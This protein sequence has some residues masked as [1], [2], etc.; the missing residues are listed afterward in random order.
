MRPQLESLLSPLVRSPLLI[1]AGDFNSPLSPLDVSN[2]HYAPWPMLSSLVSAAPPTLLNIARCLHPDSPLFS[3]YPSPLHPNSQSLLDHL[4]MTPQCHQLLPASTFFI[5]ASHTFSDHYPIHAQLTAPPFTHPTPMRTFRRPLSTQEAATF[6]SLFSTWLPQVQ[7][8]ASLPLQHHETLTAQ[9]L[10]AAAQAYLQVTKRKYRQRN[11]ANTRDALRALQAALEVAAEKRKWMAG[12]A[13]HKAFLQRRQLKRAMRSYTPTTQPPMP[14]LRATEQS[15]ATASPA[16]MAEL[17]CHTLARLGGQQD[18]QPPQSLLTSLLQHH[19][20][21]PSATLPTLSWEHFLERINRASPWKAP[22]PDGTNLYILSL[23]PQ[24]AQQV[25]WHACNLHLLHPLPPAWCWSY[26]FLL[27]KSGN[28]QLPQNYRPISLLNSVYKLIASHLLDFLAGQATAHHLLHDS[29]FGSRPGHQTLDHILHLQAAIPS[30][31]P[32]LHLYVDFNKAFNSIPHSA[33]WQLLH[34]IRIPTEALRTLQSMYTHAQEFPLVHNHPYSSFHLTRGLRQGCPLSPLLFCLYANLILA[35]ISSILSSDPDSTVH[36]FMDDILLRSP[37]PQLIAAALNFLHNEGRALGLDLN[38]HKTKLHFLS[39]TLP[40]PALPDLPDILRPLLV[41]PTAVSGYNYLGVFLADLPSY[42]HLTP[43]RDLVTSFY[44]S[45]NQLPLLA[46]E[47]VLLT[48]VQLLPRLL[49]RL[50]HHQIPFSL[51]PKLQHHIW[52]CLTTSTNIPKYLSPKDRYLP[53]R[54]GGLG[55]QSLQAAYATSLLNSIQRYLQGHAPRMTTPPILHALQS[56]TSSP[57]QATVVAAAHYAHI[58]AHGFGQENPCPPSDLPVMTS[59]YVQFSCNSWFPVTVIAQNPTII[60]EPTL[61]TTYRL[62]PSHNFALLPSPPVTTL[63]TPALPRF[64]LLPL[65]ILPFPTTSPSVPL[66][67]NLPPALPDLHPATIHLQPPFSATF[68][69][70]TP[71]GYL[72]TLPTFPPA[73]IHH[74]QE[75]DLHQLAH[76]IH[77]QPRLQIYLDGSYT[78]LS[79]GYAFALFFADSPL[80]YIFAA[81]LP[82]CS[83]FLAEWYAL[84][85][86]CTLLA[87]QPNPPTSTLIGDNSSLYLAPPTPQPRALWKQLLQQQLSSLPIQLHWVKA[88]IGVPGNELVDAFAKWAS[89]IRPPPLPA[90]PTPPSFTHNSL[91]LLLRLQRSHFYSILP[92][93]QNTS[94]VLPQSYFW[95]QHSPPL[96]IWPLKWITAT[97]SIAGFPA[98]WHIHDFFCPLCNTSHACDPISFLSFCQ[99]TAP[100]RDA[101]CSTAPPILQAP[102]RQWSAQ[103]AA[104]DRRLFFRTLIPLSLQDFLLTLPTQ[105]NT[106]P[107]LPLLLHH[108]QRPLTNLL[109]QTISWLHHHPLPQPMN[110][111]TQRRPWHHPTFS[112]SSQLPRPAPQGQTPS[113]PQTLP[114]MKRPADGPPQLAPRTSRPRLQPPAPQRKRRREFPPPP[115]HP[116]KRPHHPP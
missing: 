17:L 47:K 36:A 26:T 105:P 87:Y 67:F 76:H 38:L 1:L 103:A 107:Q 35:P 50:S 112:P 108:R 22:G 58:S 69:C 4:L 115:Q 11:P 72:F 100:F 5:D 29:Q 86:A 85:A 95:Y 90:P 20:R 81:P 73:D 63:S 66:P 14:S 78:P 19:P 51:L 97:L 16:A 91:P 45:L 70:S 114:P 33:L 74:L 98:P 61:P 42:D 23:C 101:F 94:L 68:H 3:R 56:S 65:P 60:Q 53:R 110:Q 48:N 39:P 59:L 34:H 49:Y 82:P 77:T 55:L 6:T 43:L 83:S 10:H 93:H 88:H 12:K 113:I 102:L 28:P 31:P 80:I 37:N 89:S 13:F 92:H 2:M 25:V 24:W 32:A 57:L 46:P 54:L 111:P 79:A 44:A 62:L 41:P 116:P 75:W 21:M 71:L 106:P 109:L 52:A 8:H 64:P 7:D 99:S 27:Y 9:I 84:W 40:S 30:S 18:Y 96:S 104:L 15:P